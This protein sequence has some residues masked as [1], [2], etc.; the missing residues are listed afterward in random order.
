MKNI[1]TK[2]LPVLLIFL[3]VSSFNTLCLAVETDLDD[4]SAWGETSS[5]ATE[6]DEYA[7]GLEGT[8]DI[9]SAEGTDYGYGIT[10]PST[11][12]ETSTSSTS[13]SELNEEKLKELRENVNV[14]ERALTVM[15]LEVGDY[16]QD[17]LS[18]VFR[19][20]LTVDK[21][22]F[23]DSIMLNAN[24]FDNSVKPANSSASQVVKEFINKWFAYFKRLAL[25]VVLC[26]LVVAGIK[27]ILGNAR[28]KAGA[29]QSLKKIVIAIMLIYFF[30]YVMKIVFDLNDALTMQI[31]NY[32]F[33]GNSTTLGTS[34]S[35]VSDFQKDELEF[36]SPLYVSLDSEKIGMGSDEATELYLSKIEQYSAKAD[37][38]RI[39]RAFAG[40]TGRVMYLILWYIML[41]QL[42]ALVVVY[43]KRYFT[44]AILLIVYPL[45]IVGYVSGSMFASSQTAF[46]AWCRK[47]ISTVF[48]QSIHAI[49]YGITSQMLINQIRIGNGEI[50]SMNWILMIIMT[51]FLFSGEKILARL[52]NSSV[53][54]S[55]ERMGIKHW[56]GAPKRMIGMFKG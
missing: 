51:S 49:I 30:P 13:Q 20:E 1:L 45:V 48:L 46:N 36:R 11:S 38:M 24:F 32:A 52:F 16:A 8:D 26:F 53:D 14:I 31:K 50:K 34:I 55:E 39:M 33:S 37:M 47:F 29:Y 10:I 23:N 17:Y 6:G 15:G 43:L 35:P 7:E 56:F 4:D 40:A 18:Q 25:V 3:I 28:D 9:E 5:E 44:I 12:V 27:I 19:E 2:F 22:V 21:I 42:Y 54:T 41:A